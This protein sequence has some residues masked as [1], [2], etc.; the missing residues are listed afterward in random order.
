MIRNRLLGSSL[1]SEKPDPAD[2]RRKPGRV[3]V[4]YGGYSLKAD[5]E[6]SAQLVECSFLLTE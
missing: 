3:E 6:R 5:H 1:E 2:I 4:S